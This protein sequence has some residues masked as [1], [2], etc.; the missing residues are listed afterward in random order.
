MEN[1]FVSEMKELLDN[2]LSKKISFNEFFQIFKE[3]VEKNFKP[4]DLLKAEETVKRLSAEW[5]FM[6]SPEYYEA[7]KVIESY[8]DTTKHVSED[9]D[10]SFNDR[11]ALFLKLKKEFEPD[12]EFID[13]IKEPVFLCEIGDGKNKIGFFDIENAKLIYQK[14]YEG[15][16]LLYVHKIVGSYNVYMNPQRNR[17]LVEPT[18]KNNNHIDE[19]NI[20]SYIIW[21][22]GSW[23]IK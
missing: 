16:L 20:H 21:H 23:Y 4:L 15:Q 11:K 17:V 13:I 5:G 19:S 10:L 6:S 8:K 18:D 12:S 3:K 22:Y 7:V 2:V 9:E 14:L 1:N